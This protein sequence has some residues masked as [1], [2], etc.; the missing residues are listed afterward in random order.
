MKLRLL[1]STL[2]ALHVFWIGLVAH[3]DAAGPMSASLPM[4][5]LISSVLLFIW[6]GYQAFS[7]A[8]GALKTEH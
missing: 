2:I 5:I 7:W 8:R 4:N 1:L 6:V 3:A